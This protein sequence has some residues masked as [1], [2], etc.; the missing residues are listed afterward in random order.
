MLRLWGQMPTA[1]I[2]AKCGPFQAACAPVCAGFNPP[3]A[4]SSKHLTAATNFCYTARVQGPSDI[5]PAIGS[6]SKLR[7]HRR[8]DDKRVPDFT[9]SVSGSSLNGIVVLPHCRSFPFF[10][11]VPRIYYG[12]PIKRQGEKRNMHELLLFTEIVK[13]VIIGLAAEQ[14]GRDLAKTS[15]IHL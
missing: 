12:T 3:R 2:I 4:A 6:S 7:R 14:R 13:S 5:Q 10:L 15:I 9:F 11:L 1:E 8:G